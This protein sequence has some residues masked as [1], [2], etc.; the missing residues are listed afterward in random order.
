MN[1]HVLK[2]R[3][4]RTHLLAG[5]GLVA[6]TATAS[7]APQP[8][9]PMAMPAWSWSGFYLGA[10]GGYGWGRDPQTDLIFGFK[11]P[12]PLLDV[13]SRGWVGGF[14]AGVNYQAGS[15]VG[16]VEI[17]LSAASIQ[18]SSSTATGL[19]TL[20]AVPLETTTATATQTDKFD[21]LGSLRAR[22]GYL[23]LPNVLV[24]G[25][26][27][28]A[29][30]HVIS[31]FDETASVTQAGVGSETFTDTFTQPMWRF[32]AVAGV[33]AEARL[34]NS[35]WLG[36]VEYL[37][38]DFGKS[39]STFGTN[40]SGPIITGV[41]KADVVRG[42]LS[43]KF[44]QDS[45][46]GSGGAS[47][48]SAAMPV[49]APRA[50]A[51]TWS[52]FYIGGHGGYGWGRDPFTNPNNGFNGNITLTDITS[53][54]FVAGLQAGANWQMGAWVGGL[55]LDLSG[56]GIQGSTS[57]TVPITGAVTGTDSLTETDKFELL[58]SARARVGYLARP[59][60]LLYGTGGLA[61]T[62][63]NQTTD[64]T[65]IITAGGTS[66]ASTDLE[67]FWELGW[68]AGVGAEARLW[69][70]NWLARIEYLHY[71]FGDSGSSFDNTGV[72]FSS[73]RLTADVVRGG[74]SYKFDWSGGRG[75]SGEG[76]DAAQGAPG[77]DVGLERLLSG[78][79]CRLWLGPR[80]G[81]RDGRRQR[82]RWGH[83]RPALAHRHKGQRSR[84]GFPGWRQPADGRR[85]GRA[86][87]RSLGHRHQGIDN[88]HRP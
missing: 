61:W 77:G 86:G 17:D 34:G 70:T 6:L 58:G 62:R 43:Y 12:N 76:G 81:Q 26:G 88:H 78:R 74:L 54:G 65:T 66:S 49:K 44:G 42:G 18:G 59:D 48:A 39:D 21:S 13:N 20:L 63:L 56:S 69:N 10:H 67:A 85:C 8:P 14:Q 27:G 64:Q 1:G 40:N 35:N 38:Y 2:R 75:C 5:V 53:N 79:S 52:G 83:S 3:L 73:G 82:G 60:V 46:F 57:V 30:A 51:W 33:G 11:S 36:R 68:V 7:A 25:T 37:H 9:A 4:L 41:L 72:T 84:R 31:T 16:G 29:W 19:V 87:D 22:L 45:G 80:S 47:F 32:G 23:V 24:Y 71:D 15:W 55:E 50:A 28:P